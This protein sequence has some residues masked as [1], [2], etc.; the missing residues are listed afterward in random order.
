MLI[1][2][3]M[4]VYYRIEHEV[5]SVRVNVIMF[6]TKAIAARAHI[7]HPSMILKPSDVFC[8]DS[9]GMSCYVDAECDV[10]SN[11]SKISYQS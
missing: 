10:G 4:D 1:G 8:T 2:G 5:D 3:L 7:V 11:L 9:V 6:D